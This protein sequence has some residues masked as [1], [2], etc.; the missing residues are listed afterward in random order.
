MR[1]SIDLI[2]V[3]K[4]IPRTARFILLSCAALGAA[5]TQSSGAQDYSA[6]L[7]AVA[8]LGN[9]TTAP[10]IYTDDTLPGTPATLAAGDLKIIYYDA[11]DYQGNPTRACAWVGI[12]A[13]AAITP[14]PGAVLVHGG[15]GTASQAWVQKWTERGYAAISMSVEGETET[16]ATHAMAGPARGALYNDSPSTITDQWMYHAV[17]DTVLANSLL[18][19]LPEVDAANV[20]LS[21]FSW[22]GVIT[23]TVIGIDTRFKFAIPTYGCGHLYD[24]RNYYGTNLAS[25]ELYKNVWDPMIRIANATMP[26]LWFSW[27]EEPHFPMDSLAYTYHAAPGPRMVSLK[28][29]MG[30]GGNWSSPEYYDFA[31][32]IVST[33]TP[34]C[35]QQ[36]LS[37]AGNTA[38]VVFDSTKPLHAASLVYTTGN[39]EITGDISTNLVWNE[40]AADSLVESPAG[41]WTVTATLPAGVTGWLVNVKATGSDSLNLYGYVDANITASSDYQEI[42]TLSTPGGGLAIEHP[43][44]LNESTDAVDVSYTGPANVEVSSI[45]ISAESHPGAF[46]SLTAAPLVMLNPSPTTTPVTIQ[47]DN[48]VAGL[49]DGETATATLT[50]AWDELDGGTDQ[51]SFPLSAT[52][53]AATTVVYDASANWSSQT[54]RSFDDVVI[55]NGATVTAG[56]AGPPQELVI[57][58]SFETPDAPDGSFI[59]N[60][61]AGPLDA[62]WT[63]VAG[64]VT[65]VD[66]WDT[67]Q[68]AEP[69]TSFPSE[70]EQFLQLQGTVATAGTISQTFDTTPGATYELTF[71]YSALGFDSRALT[72][73]YDVG[74]GARTVNFTSAAGQVPWATE[75]FEFTATAAT[76]TLSFT[77]QRFSGFWGPGIDNVSVREVPPNLVVNGSFEPPES[78]DLPYNGISPIAAG[79]TSLTGWTIADTDVWLIDHWD[80]FGNEPNTTAAEGDQYLQ[81]QDSGTGV[82]TISQDIT[83]VVGRDYLLSFDYSAV[84]TGSHAVEIAYTVDGSPQT[85]AFTTAS[86]Q[87]P[88]QSQTYAFQATSTT[89]TISFTGDSVGGGFYGPAIDNVIVQEAPAPN[90]VTNGSFE[91]PASPPAFN[92]FSSIGAGSTAL[93]GWTMGGSGGYLIDG[94]DRFGNEPNT[95]AADGAQYLQLQDA[96]TGV[97]TISQG[98]TT[99]VGKTYELSFDY[100]GVDTASHSVDLTYDVGGPVQT[101]TYSTGTPMLPWQ[102]ET[103]SFE[104][105]T[106]TTIISFTGDSVGGGFYGVGIDNVRVTA[107]PATAATAATITVNDD[108]SPITA[109]LAIDEDFALTATTA[110]VLGAGTGAGFVNQSNGSVTTRDLTINSSGTGDLSQYNLSGGSVDAAA[111]TVNDAGEMNLTGGTAT[112]SGTLTV[113]PGGILDID[114]GTFL[115]PGNGTIDGFGLIQLQSGTFSSGTDT[116]DGQT[117]KTDVEISGGTFSMLNQVIFSQGQPLEFRV[118]GDEASITMRHLQFSGYTGSQ[119]TLKWIFDETGVSPINVTS[120]MFLDLAKIVVDGSAYTG[121]TGTFPLLNSTHLGGLAAPG[122]ITVTGFA[123]RGLAATVVQDDQETE[124][125]SLVVTTVYENWAAGYGLSGAA[126]ATTADIENGGTGDG[127]TNLLEFGFGTDPTVSDNNSLTVTDGAN[128]TPGQPVVVVTW[129]GGNPVKLRYVRRKHH[130]AAGLI[131]TPKFTDSTGTT[132]PDPAN[133]TPTVVSD[134]GGDYEVVEV[135]FPLFDSTG[136]KVSALMAVVEVELN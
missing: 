133:P 11:L 55:R 97:A 107:L 27:P 6:E 21:G 34:W 54:V 38:T 29:G 17:A 92:S 132:I 39:D 91:T 51:V 96:G 7:A 108:P 18:R 48:T 22:G 68:G 81:L 79:N 74:G 41:T 136:E 131:Y 118:I 8:A 19:S 100:S 99:V 33:G 60:N 59:I 116:S 4:S 2:H 9:L 44:A 78:P 47:F 46:T 35:V 111:V 63:I 37:L 130:A 16:G 43:L 117:L 75:T 104:A 50:I 103:F 94:W 28:P 88:W 134:G 95:A 76:T 72:I 65:V 49:A 93:T 61:T 124:S 1:G 32:E 42:I 135:P 5:F 102:T 119:G 12:P 13:T 98:V 62:N 86:T 67:N 53:A 109:T 85:V 45:A 30:H 115:H 70:G 40:I 15:G 82:A 110:M 129:N 123:E 87:I 64:G 101:V 127:M 112:N 89:T 121:G 57:N 31:D 56:E 10:A 66:S 122:N 80:R 105:T 128:F 125:V 24:A 84:D 114:G 73:T 90:L 25:N 23:S 58:G 126:A 71:D 26:V 120:W 20:G 14:V 113:A 77:G 36:S 3:K 106:T 83:T 69:N 52:A